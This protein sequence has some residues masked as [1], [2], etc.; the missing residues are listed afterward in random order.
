MCCWGLLRRSTREMC[1]TIIMVTHDPV[2][3]SAADRVVLLADG[4]L[5]GELIGPTVE[6]VTDD[7]TALSTGAAQGASASVRGG[8]R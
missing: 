8:V 3:A 5:A 1:Q 2:A 6:S 4:V 7:M